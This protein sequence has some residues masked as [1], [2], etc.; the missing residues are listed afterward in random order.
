MSP[1]KKN[2]NGVPIK[3]VTPAIDTESKENINEDVDIKVNIS[4]MDTPKKEEAP[5]N[6]GEVILILSDF[7]AVVATKDS[8]NH[9]VRNNGYAIGDEVYF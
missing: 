8:G 9:T 2:N 6:H 4:I 3:R 1:R 7:E 5:K